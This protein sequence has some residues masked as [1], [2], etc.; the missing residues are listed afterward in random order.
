MEINEL[1]DKPEVGLKGAKT[2]MLT[3][4]DMFGVYPQCIARL[5]QDILREMVGEAVN[6]VDDVTALAEVWKKVGP[7]ERW[8]RWERWGRGIPRW[9]LIICLV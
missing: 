9:R 1:L 3:R 7:F 6:V 8:E 5:K 2:W 4:N